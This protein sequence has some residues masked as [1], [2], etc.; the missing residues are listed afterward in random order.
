M[1]DFLS[2][3][4]S[5]NFFNYLLPGALFVFT[6]KHF[7]LFLFKE[8]HI[9]VELFVYYFVGMTVSRVGSVIIEPLFKWLCVVAYA[10]YD[11]YLTA[12]KSDKQIEILLEQNNTYRT[13]VALFVC[14]FSLYIASWI[15]KFF[16][17][18]NN[19]IAVSFGAAILLL[20]ILAY[21][22]QTAYIRKR[23]K[24]QNQS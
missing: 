9:I 18:P 12:V 23:V 10:P 17:L 13:I 15:I 8:Q 6:I 19:L 14:L 21:R 24:K 5:Y 20:Y 2:K 7:E 22:K 16:G 3:L 1:S 11:D 4:S